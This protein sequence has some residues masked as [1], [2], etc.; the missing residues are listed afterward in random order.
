MV[1]PENAAQGL[2]AKLVVVLQKYLREDFAFHFYAAGKP[3]KN[4]LH[5]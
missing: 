4:E 3:F 5:F 2:I 1:V